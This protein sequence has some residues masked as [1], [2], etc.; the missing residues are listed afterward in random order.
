MPDDILYYRH[1]YNRTKG[2]CNVSVW[3]FLFWMIS[4]NRKNTILDALQHFLQILDV[5]L[6]PFRE[7]FMTYNQFILVLQDIVSPDGTQWLTSF[8]LVFGTNFACLKQTLP[9]AKSTT[10]ISNVVQLDKKKTE[11]VELQPSPC[12]PLSWVRQAQCTPLRWARL[13]HSWQEV[14][15]GLILEMFC[16]KHNLEKS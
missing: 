10:K 8:P 1:D 5:V 16:Y 9:L 11:V 15:K 3:V 13:L 14:V 2:Y 6:K 4:L 7:R 12:A